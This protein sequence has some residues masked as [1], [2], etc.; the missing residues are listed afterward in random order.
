MSKVGDCGRTRSG[1]AC[2]SRANSNTNA[3]PMRLI[4]KSDRTPC[5]PSVIVNSKHG[6]AKKSNGTISE[7]VEPQ[8]QLRC[9]HRD[10][11]PAAHPLLLSSGLVLFRIRLPSSTA[12]LLAGCT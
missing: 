3:H 9:Y 4:S 11:V 8:G 10:I 6:M 5:R 7:G 2:T 1:S 12:I